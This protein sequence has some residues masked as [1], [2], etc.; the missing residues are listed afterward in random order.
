MPIDAADELYESI[1]RDQDGRREDR[2]S[3]RLEAFE[4]RQS[5][6]PS[7]YPGALARPVRVAGSTCH[8]GA[9]STA[10]RPSPGLASARRRRLQRRRLAV[11]SPRSRGGLVYAET[12]SELPPSPCSRATT[13]SGTRFPVELSHAVHQGRRPRSRDSDHRTDPPPAGHRPRTRLDCEDADPGK[14]LARPSTGR[15]RTFRSRERSLPR[16]PDGRSRRQ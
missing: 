6:G 7:V 1:R 16:G 3:H 4:H 5:Q 9:G 14:G 2:S 8:P 10:T 15:G 12:R 13:V 11:A